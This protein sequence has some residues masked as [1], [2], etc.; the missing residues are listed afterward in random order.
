MAAQ[1]FEQRQQAGEHQHLGD[2]RARS[3]ARIDQARQ[4][5]EQAEQHRQADHGEGRH[6]ALVLGVDEEGL[7]HPPAADQEIGRPR[8]KAAR[9][10]R[11]QRPRRIGPLPQGEQQAIAQK[12]GQDAER[13]MGQ[14]RGGA[15]RERQARGAKFGQ[16]AHAWAS[17]SA[18]A[19]GS[20]LRTRTRVMRRGSASSTSNSRPSGWAITSP[21]CGTRPARAATRPATVSISSSRSS[22]ARAWPSA[23]SSSSSEARASASYAPARARD[24]VGRGRFV[25]FV[26]DLAVHRVDQVLQGDQA[27]GAAELVDHQGQM[28]ARA[29]H[30]QQQVRRAHRSGHEQHLAAQPVQH[31]IGGRRGRGPA[32]G[33]QQF[34]HVLDIGHPHRI[35]EGVAVD[36]HA[37]VLDLGELAHHL[38]E[39]GGDL[40]GH[41]VRAGGHHVGDAQR[42]EHFPAWST[43]S[44]G[45]AAATAAAVRAAA[46][47]Q[48][49]PC[50]SCGGANGE[51]GAHPATSGNR[52]GLGRGAGESMKA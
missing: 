28:H 52:R 11:S 36:R 18:A 15:R 29:L 23:A 41:D 37:R 17:P 1:P 9:K 5:P 34:E 30:A 24:D 8:A 31:R 12:T 10:A 40:D 6:P 22:G 4:A 35:V 48:D 39:R 46:A 3:Q 38:L 19:G 25:V 47:R 33:G 20:S 14:G 26:V 16:P 49:W 7:G 2:R 13:R 50:P 21:R 27:V 42:L 32:V 43:M 45:P 51:H 44:T